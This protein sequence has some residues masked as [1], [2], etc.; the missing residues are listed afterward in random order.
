MA[1][2][3]RGRRKAWPSVNRTRNIR[4]PQIS[5]A[6]RFSRTYDMIAPSNTT[7]AEL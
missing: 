6:P 7:I 2:D 1:P 4:T 5:A 3:M